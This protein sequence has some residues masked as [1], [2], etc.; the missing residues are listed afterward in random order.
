MDN[1]QRGEIS[2]ES[3]REREI[4]IGYYGY[5][6]EHRKIYTHTHT[7]ASRLLKG[8]RLKRRK[9]LTLKIALAVVLPE[10]ASNSRRTRSKK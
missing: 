8:I 6:R 4:E 3:E 7:Q 9:I 10:R 2:K 5:G 1:E